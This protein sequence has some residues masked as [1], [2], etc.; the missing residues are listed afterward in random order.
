MPLAAPAQARRRA[1]WRLPGS[2]LRHARIELDGHAAD[3]GVRPV[4]AQHRYV[5]PKR[6]ANRQHAWH[7]HSRIEAHLL[8]LCA[9][10]HTCRRSAVHAA[11]QAETSF[12]TSAEATP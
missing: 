4:P 11:D 3:C 6:G 7:Y 1:M 8:G 12:A 9:A 2:D 10:A 5:Q